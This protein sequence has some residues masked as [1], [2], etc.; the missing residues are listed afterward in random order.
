[1]E[2]WFMLLVSL[3]IAAIL[4]AFFKIL[5]PTK[6][7]ILNLPPSPSTIPIITDILWLFKSLT[8]LESILKSIIAKLGPIVT[9]DIGF[10]RIIF[11]EDHSIAHQALVRNGAVFAS[12]PPSLATTKIVNSNQSTINTSLYGPTWRLLRRNLTSQI[13]HPTRSRSYSHARKWVIQILMDRLLSESQSGEPVLVK[14]HF[15]FAMFCLLVLMCFGDKLSEKQIKEVEEVQRRFALNL[16]RFN[17]FNIWPSVTKILLRKRWQQM[18]SLRR[19]QEAVLIPLIEARK[20]ANREGINKV[21]DEDYVL[22]YV[23]TLLDL[24]IPHENRKLDEGEMVSLCNEF[25]NGGTDTTSTALQWIMA[26]LVKYPHIQEKLFRE[27]KGVVGEGEVVVKEDELQRMPYLKAVVL[28]GLRRH[29]PGH[30]VLPHAVTEEVMLDQYLI[31]K[32]S[33]VNFMVA[34]MGWDPKV[35]EDPM[36]FKPERFMS[37]DGEVVFD[38]TGNKEIKMMPFGVGRR[39]CPGLGLAMLHLEYFVANLV[40]NLEWK[41]KDGD[42]VDLSEKQELTTVMKT[43]LEVH[44]FPR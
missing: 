13:L 22:S 37:S 1:M 16:L 14:E 3:S 30:F 5:I 7:Q 28:E 24:E 19:D 20:K 35:W 27:I 26:N 4:K 17:V 29:P 43:S 38:I 8:G 42:E 2:A 40:W 44:V 6:Q 12:R 10:R 23:D 18:L 39:I 33:T 15:Q 36:G 25:L 31:P 32:N 9:L 21:E 41:A 34:Q 11:V